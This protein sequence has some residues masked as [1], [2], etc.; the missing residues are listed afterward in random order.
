MNRFS[1]E[2]NDCDK[3]IMPDVKLLTTIEIHLSEMAAI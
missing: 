3:N 2:N 1:F